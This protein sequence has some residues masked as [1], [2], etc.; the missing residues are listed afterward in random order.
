MIRSIFRYVYGT[1][2]I[3]APMKFGKGLTK[4]SAAEKRKATQGA[5]LANGNNLLTRQEILCIIKARSA[6]MLGAVMLGING[7]FGNTD[8]AGLPLSAVDLDAAVT[9]R[10]TRASRSACRVSPREEAGGGSPP[11]SQIGVQLSDYC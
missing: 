9:T 11:S 7:G 1:D 10:A 4:P 5:E 2:L 3:G 6:E 8:C